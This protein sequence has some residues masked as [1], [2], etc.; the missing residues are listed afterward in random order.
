MATILDDTVRII[1]PPGRAA[2]PAAAR[3]D[4]RAAVLR[5]MTDIYPRTHSPER[6]RDQRY[7]YPQLITLRPVGIDG[8]TPLDE[9]LVVV[10]KHI[11]ESGLGFFHPHP[12]PHRRVVATMPTTTGATLALL[13]DVSWCRF[14]RHGWY[15]SGGRFLQ[16]VEVPEAARAQSPG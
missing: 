13:L 4:V 12:L 14:T 16:T 5:I 15:E 9:Q 3:E 8:V 2:T 6:R 10:G 11:S 7:P 1:S